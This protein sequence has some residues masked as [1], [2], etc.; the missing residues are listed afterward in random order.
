MI[1][2]RT[3][4][5]PPITAP[6]YCP[7]SDSTVPIAASSVHERWQLGSVLLREAAAEE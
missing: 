7:L 1:A 5:S 4:P 3:I 2:G 6:P